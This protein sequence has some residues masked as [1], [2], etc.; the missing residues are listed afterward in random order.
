MI[1][2]EI[3]VRLDQLDDQ[4]DIGMS[5][6][7]GRLSSPD[8]V[9]EEFYQSSHGPQGSKGDKGPPG[10]K[11]DRRPAG[12][13]G[14]AGPGWSAGATGARGLTGPKGDQGLKEIQV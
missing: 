8:T 11:G 6:E 9:I 3:G 5:Y 4:L 12:P 7:M 14:P 2:R 13:A 1:Q 10:P